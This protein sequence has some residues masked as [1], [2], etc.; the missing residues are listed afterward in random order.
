[1]KW[2]FGKREIKLAIYIRDGII[3]REEA[4]AQISEKDGEPAELD[5]W[6]KKL[7]LSRGD[8]AKVKHLSY[9]GFKT[10]NVGM[11]KLLRKY[12]NLVSHP[13][14]EKI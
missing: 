9:D 7:D 10:Y 12:T 5:Y 3:S 6:L 13:Y 11:L 1:M 8:L 2:G 14:T 4:L